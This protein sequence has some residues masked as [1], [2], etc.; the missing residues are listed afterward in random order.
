MATI[1]LARPDVLN[2][3]D[4]LTAAELGEACGE[5]ASDDQVHLVVLTG[6]GTAFSVGREAAP[7]GLSLSAGTAGMQWLT[8]MQCAAAVAS[9]PMPVI[10]AINGDAIDQGLE[11]ALAGDLRVASEHAW[12]GIS[13]LAHGR[14][15]SD[16]ATQRLPRLVGQAWAR[17]LLLTSRI[18]DSA[19]ALEIGLVNRVAG[20]GRLEAETRDLA[21][22][23]LSGGPVAARYAKEALSQGLDLTLEQGLRLEADLNVV[24]QSTGD[25]AEGIESFLHK[26]PPN[27]TGQ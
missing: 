19:Q 26:R 11:L 7:A 5:I 18:I 12:F 3:I 6:S 14:L 9:L 1:T 2:R 16:G 20:P 22:A 23:I 27:Y 15:P 17:D 13:D 4:A 25:R 10:V 24:L 8:S 21:D